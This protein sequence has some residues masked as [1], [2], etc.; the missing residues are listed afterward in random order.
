MSASEGL[1]PGPELP[2]DDG[3]DVRGHQ[4]LEAPLAR[5]PLADV[6]EE[7]LGERVEELGRCGAVLHYGPLRQ[8]LQKVPLRLADPPSERRELGAA[9][10]PLRWSAA[11]R[12]QIT[13]HLTFPIASH[14]R[15]RSGRAA[16]RPPP[17]RRRG[18]RSAPPSGDRQLVVAEPPRA[19]HQ[20]ADV[21]R[22]VAEVAELPVDHRGQAIV[23][24]D[25][26]AEAEIAVDQ[27]GRAAGPAGSAAASAVPPRPREAARRSRR[28][29]SPRSHRRRVRG[30]RPTAGTPSRLAG[31]SRGSPPAPRR[32]A[33][34][35]A[36]G[37]PR[38]RRGAGAGAPPRCPP[39][40]PSGIRRSRTGRRRARGKRP[41]HRHAGPRPRFDQR[42]LDR[43][44][45][46]RT[47][48]PADRGGGPS[49]LVG[50]AT[51]KVWRD[52]PP[53]IGVSAT[54]PGSPPSASV[55]AERTSR[56]PVQSRARRTIVIFG[57]CPATT[58]RP[59]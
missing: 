51:R 28:A 55:S 4:D 24:G 14:Q 2:G 59:P 31:R 7:Q 13:A 27:P 9:P 41:R 49:A 25:E 38:T 37:P 46:R 47:D 6:R 48:A 44:R 11:W 5:H 43:E 54:A 45:R 20:P 22:R 39:R 26:V 29:P 16:G 1:V 50:R 10:P 34:G 57:S 52:A 19:D 40:A 32:A 35:G 3:A 53:G 33:P 36:R 15:R 23:V 12:A 56:A 17:R 42:E 21:L 18:T 8:Q 30:R 58:R